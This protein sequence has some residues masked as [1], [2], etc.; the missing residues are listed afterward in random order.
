MIPSLYFIFESTVQNTYLSTQVR[1]QSER[2]QKVIS[3]GVYGFVR[4]PQYL[5]VVLM[6]IGG[7]LLL[8]SVYGVII[9]LIVIIIFIFRILGEEKMLA[10][11]LEGY[12]DYKKKIKYRLLPIVW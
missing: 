4:H 7:P 12:K 3:A 2:K 8:N 1:I 10:E 5:G 9:G 11:E 6:C